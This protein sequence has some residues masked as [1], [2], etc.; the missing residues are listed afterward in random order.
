MKVF[1]LATLG[2]NRG[3]LT[4]S[5]NAALQLKLADVVVPFASFEAARDAV[6]SEYA[7]AFLVPGAYRG[8]SAFIMDGALEVI[9]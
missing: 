7:D 9:S 4:C 2:S 3:N 5:M 1:R 8:L 6:G